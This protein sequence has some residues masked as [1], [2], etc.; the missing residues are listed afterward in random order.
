[1]QSVVVRDF[2][3]KNDTVDLSNGWIQGA[4]DLQQVNKAGASI[5]GTLD[6]RVR[7]ADSVA[8]EV[9]RQISIIV[10]NRL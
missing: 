1:M 3:E 9:D 4:S 6:V 8:D 2:S 10:S 7:N 5:I